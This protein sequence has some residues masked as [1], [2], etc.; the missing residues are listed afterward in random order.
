[1][2]PS[3]R[4]FLIILLITVLVLSVTIGTFEAGKGLGA[5]LFRQ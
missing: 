4:Q 3:P 1:M 2:A 5:A